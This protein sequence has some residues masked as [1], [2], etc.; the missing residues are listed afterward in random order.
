MMRCC[1]MVNPSIPK[2]LVG[3]FQ[4]IVVT[5]IIANSCQTCFVSTWLLSALDFSS[6]MVRVV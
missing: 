6:A 3:R 4:T 2:A 5:M 1:T